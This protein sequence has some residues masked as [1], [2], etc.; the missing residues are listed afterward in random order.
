MPL[1]LHIIGMLAALMIMA[2]CSSTPVSRSG[3]G[4]QTSA[5]SNPEGEED[6]S[7]EA[8]ERRTEAHA[9]YATG[10]VLDLN[11][12]PEAAV[13]EYF[14]AALADVRDEQL[15]LEVTRRLLQ[16]RQQEK[17]LELL[18]KATE[19]PNASGQL[20]A[21]L[22]M[23]YSMVG[24]KEEAI[25]ANRTA[26]RK[27]PHSLAGYQNLV[28][29]HLQ[30][31][32][33]EEAMKVLE[34]AARQ[35]NAEPILLVELADLYA[36]IMRGGGGDAAKEKALEMLGRAD[37]LNPA[38]PLLQQKLA[39]SLAALGESDR[40]AELY[41][42]LL[43]K[44]PNL[45][46]LREKL[47]ELYIRGKDRKKAIEQL[48]AIVRTNPTSAQAYYM[49]GSLAFDEKDYKK[50]VEH[51]S[52]AL[53]LTPNF[54]QLYY[55]LAGAYVNANQPR[56]ALK[57][58]EKARGRFQ[59]HFVNEYFTAM[60]HNRLKDHTNALKHLVAAEVIAR[61]T[62]TN[63]LTQGFYFQLGAAYERTQNYTEAEKYFRRCLQMDPKFSEAMNYLGYMWTE[64][65]VNL[66]EAHRLIEKAVGLEPKNAAYLDSLGW[67]L[68]KLER[69]Q[70]A[71]EW[72]R[73]AI[74]HAEEP[75]ATLYDHLGDVYAS[76]DQLSEA[77]EAWQK[78]LAL[79]PNSE[80]EKKLGARDTSEKK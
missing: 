28:H 16:L 5:K 10:V 37:K 2:G 44:Y 32:Q 57:T 47:T 77:R 33:P 15:V 17:A 9:R 14:K 36:T 35:P 64:R 21:R 56:E 40:A 80:I 4:K 3:A 63:R 75:D 7:P 55:D 31:R 51:L 29:I 25:E 19:A 23:V 34:P 78:A 49:L 24:K 70:E 20:Y 48:E 8:L 79:E 68:F 67:V 1:C 13:E 76:L 41:L 66:N 42:K 12:N 30:A 71:L 74:Q 65:G 54:E 62:E 38:N 59:P 69:P 53:L 52:K 60:A 43:E 72:L 58:L 27:S 46:T 73:K 11:D 39:D 22:G 26:I 6:R 18:K 61:A 45:P 50:A